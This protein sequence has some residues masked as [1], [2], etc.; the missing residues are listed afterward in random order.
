MQRR[1]RCSLGWIVETSSRLG[2]GQDEPGQAGRGVYSF[3]RAAARHS[4]SISEGRC[5]PYC[6]ESCADESRPL[7]AG[8]RLEETCKLIFLLEES[9]SVV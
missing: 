5:R 4:F 3:V 2:A 7:Y 8:S 6:R 9:I 1:P